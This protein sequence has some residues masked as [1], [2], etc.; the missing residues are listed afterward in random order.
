MF[1]LTPS[2]IRNTACVAFILTFLTCMTAPI[3][4][5][6]GERP[7]IIVLLSDDQGWGDVGY[8]G[9]PVLHTPNLDDMAS[10]GVRFDRFYAAG[11]VCT[12]TRA[13]LLTGRHPN[14]MGAFTW[15][16]SLRPQELTLPEIL[17]QHGY[18]TAHF[19]K[20][21]VG[22][23][24]SESPVNP[25]ASGFQEWISAPNF[26]DFS[27]LLSHKGEVVET[28]GEGSEIIVDLA[29]DFLESRA[30]DDGPFFIAIWFGNP[31][32]P[33][34]A[35]DEDRILYSDYPE[36]VANFYAE[37]TAIDRT[38]GTLRTYLEQSGLRENTIV[39]YLGDN[40][41]LPDI[42]LN[43][44]RESKGSIYEGGLR[45]PSVM[46]WP[47]GFPQP[48]IIE[49]PAST[50]DVLPT[51]LDVA[52]IAYPA[53][54]PLDGTSLLDTIR[55]ETAD[56]SRPLTFW[57]F[58]D[59]PGIRMNSDT[60]MSIAS[61]DGDDENAAD[62]LYLDAGVIRTTY[63]EDFFEGHAAILEWPWKL[64]RIEKSAWY[65][66]AWSRN[67]VTE[68]YNLEDDPLETTNL[69][70]ER[71]D[72]AM[73]LMADLEEWQASVIRSLNGEDY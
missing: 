11:H 35:E 5:D 40:G 41:G 38:V 14:R 37:T 65:D 69:I 6:L 4:N 67:P 28:N 50:S 24:L 63:D 47:R 21:H 26:F 66:F 45:V 34:I 23:V 31:H 62:L 61:N 25:G 7:N 49:T 19:G 72:V 20:W 10:E 70:E 54:R 3:A 30:E 12:P 52:N 1:G 8:N 22:S 46:E 51:I 55:S 73:R 58:Y 53:S 32:K 43:G 33:H 64:H 39:W 16:H 48:Q 2:L 18:T 71:E 15:G 17:S 9:H 57:K 13:S 56:F 27:P 29:I 42:G 68:L 59:V 36:D 60:I 44:G